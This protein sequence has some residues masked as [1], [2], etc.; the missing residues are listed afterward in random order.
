MVR[1]K[2]KI[3]RGKESDGIFLLYWW[4]REG[5]MIQRRWARWVLSHD[6]SCGATLTAASVCLQLWINRLEARELVWRKETHIPAGRRTW[7]PGLVKESEPKTGGVPIRPEACE[8][9]SPMTDWSV[10]CLPSEG[11]LN[12]RSSRG[13]G[14]LPWSCSSDRT[15]KDSYLP[16]K[17][18]SAATGLS[19]QDRKLSVF[20]CRSF[21]GDHKRY[22]IYVIRCV[23]VH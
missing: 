13:R 12:H 14:Q 19:W 4:E 15:D 20:C 23:L 11:N 5:D 22:N 7:E 3:L 21:T 2:L 1:G 9:V 6:G 10:G 16:P 17:I 8:H 18:S